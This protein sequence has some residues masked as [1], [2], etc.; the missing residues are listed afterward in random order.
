MN[1]ELI[2]F[3]GVAV[4][5]P[6]EMLSFETVNTEAVKKGY[7]VHPDACTESVMKFIN[8]I[9][10]DYNSTFYKQQLT[11]LISKEMLGFPTRTMLKQKTLYSTSTLSS[12]QYPPRRCTINVLT[13]CTVELH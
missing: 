11:E 6:S 1:T 13:C 9:N 8:E 12:R 4:S 2:K 7:I 10:V 3:F 5:E